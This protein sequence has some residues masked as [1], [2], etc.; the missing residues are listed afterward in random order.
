MPSSRY[1]V[2]LP[3]PLNT[4]VQDYIS[5]T[6]TSFAVLIRNALS[7]YLADTA[8]D[9]AVSSTA[10]SIPTPADS[11]DILREIQTR[12]AALTVR[13][14]VLEEG[15]RELT[16]STLATESRASRQDTD[17]SAATVPTAA[18]TSRTRLPVGRRK[19]TPRQGRA[20]RDKH[21]RG[22]SIAALQEEYGISRASVFRYLQSNKR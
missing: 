9:R 1:T 22:V 5:S 12:L 3:E 15:F 21:L 4:L 8:A 2:H 16:F 19:L 13:V 11:T 7:A 17:S 14:E 6:K 20:L 18:G 10:D